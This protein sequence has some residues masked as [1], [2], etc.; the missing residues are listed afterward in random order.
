MKKGLNFIFFNDF[1]SFTYADRSHLN[2]Y[3][4]RFL[5]CTYLKYRL[6]APDFIT[7]YHHAADFH[8]PSAHLF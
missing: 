4:N 5:P 7:S 2:F 3:A 6:E 1:K 8:D